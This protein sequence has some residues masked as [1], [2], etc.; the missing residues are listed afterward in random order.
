MYIVRCNMYLYL[1]LL[2]FIDFS[3]RSIGDYNNIRARKII[4]S[5]SFVVPR[6]F[7]CN[8]IE[9]LW[10]PSYLDDIRVEVDQS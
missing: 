2:F 4:Y 8:N 5:Q 3:C 6:V 9:K 7:I 10:C 1:F